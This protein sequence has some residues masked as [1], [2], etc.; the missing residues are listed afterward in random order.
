[1]PASQLDFQERSETCVCSIA[2]TESSLLCQHLT[3]NSSRRSTES[4]AVRQEDIKGI[5][6][7]M[8]C[9]AEVL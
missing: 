9:D 6:Q 2:K 4:S 3:M 5:L 8:T 7:Q 1:M